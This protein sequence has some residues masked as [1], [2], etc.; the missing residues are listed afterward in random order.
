MLGES[1]SQ[2]IMGLFGTGFNPQRFAI[3]SDGLIDLSLFGESKSQIVER[4]CGIGL[5]L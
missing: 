4:L 2:V 5:N 3:M 1:I